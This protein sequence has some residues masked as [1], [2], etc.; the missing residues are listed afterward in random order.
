MALCTVNINF[1]E[2]KLAN[3]SLLYVFWLLSLC[4][5]HG[6]FLLFNF[7]CQVRRKE[8]T[9]TQLKKMSKFKTMKSENLQSSMTVLFL[10]QLTL[11]EKMLMLWWSLC[12]TRKGQSTSASSARS[13]VIYQWYVLYSKF[14][15][16]YIYSRIAYLATE[17]HSG[18]SEKRPWNF[19]IYCIVPV[20]WVIKSRI[21]GNKGELEPNI[22]HTAGFWIY[23][24]VFQCTRL[25]FCCQGFCSFVQDIS[26]ITDHIFRG[27]CP[28]TTTVIF[29]F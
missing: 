18:N 12:L 26:Y 14:K 19:L 2:L 16:T 4:F 1:L 8:K 15:W 25:T 13:S 27:S 5:H 11:L 10:R 20:V 24:L 21:Y 3:S 28:F 9:W 17:I 29:L 7:F 23:T 22:G 6:V